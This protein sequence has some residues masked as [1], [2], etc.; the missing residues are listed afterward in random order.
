[1]A[2]RKSDRSAGRFELAW[3]AA[4][5]LEWQADRWRGAYGTSIFASDNSVVEDVDLEGVRQISNR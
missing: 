5:T 1:M 4:V 3:S 2:R